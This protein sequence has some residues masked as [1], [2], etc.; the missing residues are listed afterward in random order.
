MFENVV[1]YFSPRL[2]KLENNFLFEIFFSSDFFQGGPNQIEIIWRIWGCFVGS[3]DFWG[4]G[5]F[6]FGG[7]P[8][9]NFFWHE[10][11]S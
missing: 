8:L 6:F 1:R 10:F 2:D 7:G 11:S 4:A 5:D 3:G 9:P